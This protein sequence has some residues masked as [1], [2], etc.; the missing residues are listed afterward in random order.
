MSNTI[1]GTSIIQAISNQVSAD[2]AAEAVILNLNSGV[3]YGLD[4]VGT[5]I[6][7]LTREPRCVN[8]IRDV[9]F[10]EYDV[11]PER[12]EQ[13]LHALLGQLMEAGLIEVKDASSAS[14]PA[15]SPG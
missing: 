8:E 9:I 10:S 11:T 4:L 6:W 13:D 15:T 7:E 1:S 14:V 2:L 5:R 3:Y 12:C